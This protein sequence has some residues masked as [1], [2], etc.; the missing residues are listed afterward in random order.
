MRP[1]LNAI[2]SIARF[3]GVIFSTAFFL[4]AISA[5]P[6]AAGELASQRVAAGLDYPVFATSPPGDPRLFIVEQGGRIKVLKH[7]QVLPTPFLDIHT[8]V[9]QPAGFEQRGL[10]GL[11]FHPQYAGS[12]FFYLMYSDLDW[13]INIVRYRASASNPDIADPASAFVVLR[14]ILPAPNHIGGTLNFGPNDGYLYIG[15]GD[16]GEQG[17]PANFAQRDDLLFG[18]MLRID[19]NNGVPYG[20][21]PS[22]PF[23]GPGLPLDEIWAKGFRNP[24]RWS[25]DRETSDLYIGDVGQS[26][27]EEID[28][29]SAGSKGGENY[30]WHMMEGNHCYNPPQGCSSAGLILPIHEYQHIFHCSVTG[31]YVYRGS[32]IPSAQGTY[33]FADYCTG[34]IWSFRYQ[35]GLVSNFTDRTPE[36]SPQG[37]V[38][39][40]A[41]FAEDSAGELY[42]VD[43]DKVEGQG[44]IWRIVPGAGSTGVDP[45]ADIPPEAALRLVPAS[46]NPFSEQTQINVRIG[47]VPSSVRAIVY[48]A[49]GRFVDELA[50][51]PVALGSGAAA[52]EWDGR[53][54]NGLPCPSGIYMLRVAADGQEARERLILIR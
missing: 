43:H 30:G 54:A 27:W 52:L 19:V 31:G 26:M 24:Y 14:M 28:Y 22:N 7:G 13:R 34:T 46:P 53:D 1:S 10:M 18:K 32:A 35:N 23:A 12:R 47:Y 20:I 9:S 48:S 37:E 2:G 17:D 3:R 11:A 33:F 15:I 21:P 6:I 40:I 38:A 4:F 51:D 45:D 36:L 8:L 42:M 44:E 49:A 39:W 5:D 16:G 41:S 25:F 29:Q 50:V